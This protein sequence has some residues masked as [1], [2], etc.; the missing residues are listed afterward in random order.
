MRV[1]REFDVHTVQAPYCILFRIDSEVWCTQREPERV[2]P[3][4]IGRALHRVG[5]Y[6]LYQFT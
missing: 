4:Y 2:R 5:L 1:G 3:F 6:P